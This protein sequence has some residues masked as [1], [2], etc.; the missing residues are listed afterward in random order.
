MNKLSKT[1]QKSLEM[2]T[3]SAKMTGHADSRLD[4]PNSDDSDIVAFLE[5]FWQLVHLH[6]A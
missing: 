2:P 3:A 1:K 4:F 6:T 5:I